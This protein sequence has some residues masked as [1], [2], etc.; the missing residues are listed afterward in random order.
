M[1]QEAGN[2][3]ARLIAPEL[4]V[5]FR[6]SPSFEWHQVESRVHL[7]NQHSHKTPDRGETICGDLVDLNATDTFRQRFVLLT[8]V[9]PE[10]ICKICAGAC[11]IE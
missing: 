2:T 3:M 11:L 5:Q 8:D 10:K 7:L 6:G 9:A 4:G 1:K